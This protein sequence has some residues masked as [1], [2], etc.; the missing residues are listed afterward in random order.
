[1][2]A[3]A[4]N[5]LREEITVALECRRKVRLSQKFTYNP[6]TK[7]GDDTQA[8]IVTYLLAQTINHCFGEI[9]NSEEGFAWQTLR[10]NLDIW[11]SGLPRSFQP[12]SIAAKPDSVFPSYWMLRPWHSMSLNSS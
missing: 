10:D 12:Y 5:Y 4:W 8:N 11:K 2:Q 7:V 6:Q 3:G 9:T 1:M